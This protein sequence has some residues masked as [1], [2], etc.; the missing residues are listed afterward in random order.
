MTSYR[1][2][3]ATDGP[4][5]AVS[6]SGNFISG[7]VFG[8]SGGGKWFEGYW[9]WVA[10]TGQSTAPV[11]CALW[12]VIA[13]AVGG[14]VVPGSVVTSGALTAGQ[15]NYI[16]L[17]EPVQLAPSW[18]ANATLNGSSYI[19]AVGCNGNFPDTNNYF[20]AGNPGGNGITNG[21]LIAYAANSAGTTNVAPPGMAN[22]VFATS[23]SDPSLIMPAG[24]SNNGDSF[25]VDVQVT[26]Q[27]PAGYSGS[28]R[29]YP[30]KADANNVVTSDAAFNYTIATEVHLSESC[31]LDAVW[32]FRPNGA[33]TMATRCDVWNI[34]TGL[35]VASITSPVWL[36]SSGAA[37]ANGPGGIGT[38]AQA[39]F[40]DGVTLPAGSYRVSVYNANGT[41]DA[42]WSA[43]DAFSD[44]FGE[45]FP[46]AGAD[47]ID[48]GVINAPNW[49]NASAG[50]L[51]GGDGSSTPPFG[52][53]GATPHAQPVFAQ[54]ASGE[55]AFPQL[56]APVGAGTNQTQNYFVDL[57]VTPVGGNM[58]NRSIPPTVLPAEVMVSQQVLTSL[59]IG[60]VAVI[61]NVRNCVLRI[62]NGAA[63]A[64]VTIAGGHGAN[65]LKFQVVA[66]GTVY[67]R[68]S[69]TSLYMQSDDTMHLTADQILSSIV[70]LD[71]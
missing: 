65:P 7:L 32:Y 23:G 4:S 70:V 36:N 68:L 2:W 61:P 60:D 25:W 12:S 44:Y 58:A 5:T 53:G 16:P 51:Y 49:A 56:N 19:A 69:D 8:V 38:W 26:D 43:K 29:L 40:P 9:W 35:S 50:F 11:K 71:W 45:T 63:A 54:G 30:N 34:A 28:Y 52:G 31:T 33:S 46:G 20:A 24:G 18:D 17:P 59:A 48:W 22:G 47:G 10:P 42:N 15:W 3:P 62:Q 57:E 6:Y 1:L 27:A 14:M 55:V 41:S 66:S 39:Q 37:F 13:P 21:P 67:V 64:N